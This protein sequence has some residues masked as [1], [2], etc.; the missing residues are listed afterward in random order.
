MPTALTDSIF[1]FHFLLRYCIY[2][3]MDEG[4]VCSNSML[5]WFHQYLL[6]F[7]YYVENNNWEQRRGMHQNKEENYVINR[8]I[9]HFTLRKPK[10]T[11]LHF[12][13]LKNHKY[14]IQNILPVKVYW[15]DTVIKLLN[16]DQLA[17]RTK[18]KFWLDT[19]ALSIFQLKVSHYLP[20]LIF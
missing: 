16:W 17:E 10:H 2:M 18:E 9:S 20:L 13:N 15:T 5:G 8:T 3:T 6:H 19:F 14:I 11:N 7:S 1:S 4:L 12:K